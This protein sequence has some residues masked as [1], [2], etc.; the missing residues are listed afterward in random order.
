MD[1]ND[2]PKLAEIYCQRLDTAALARHFAAWKK[3]D[4]DAKSYI[5]ANLPTNDERYL[6]DILAAFGNVDYHVISMAQRWLRQQKLPVH[7]TVCGIFISTDGAK[8][9]QD[10]LISAIP[11]RPKFDKFCADI[12]SQP[13]EALYTNFLSATRNVVKT[14]YHPFRK[15]KEY[16]MGSE[17]EL[18]GVILD[19]STAYTINQPSNV[20]G[21]LSIGEAAELLSVREKQLYAWLQR[22]K[23]CCTCRNGR[24]LLTE[25]YVR[26]LRT[27]WSN[28]TP[29][30]PIVL[31]QLSVLPVGKRRDVQTIVMLCAQA[32][33]TWV[34]PD[35]EYPQQTV[36][37]Y[38]TNDVQSAREHI[39]GIIEKQHILPLRL[40]QNVTGLSLA[41]LRA[42]VESGCI[43]A[44]ASDG[45]FFITLAEQQRIVDINQRYVT[46]DVLVKVLLSETDEF[47]I[48]KV[49]HRS[50]LRDFI[51]Q[52]DWWDIDYID[53]AESPVDGGKFG[54]LIPCDDAVDLQNHI[55]C[56]IKGYG[57]SYA[58]Q[59]ELLLK[60]Y[61]TKLPK[62]VESLR[63]E[64]VRYLWEPNKAAVDMIDTL[65]YWLPK[66]LHTMLRTDLDKHIMCKFVNCTLASC[67]ELNKFLLK[68]GII[69]NPYEF[70]RTS[71]RVDTSAYSLVDYATMV[72]AI[73]CDDVIAE[74][75][76]VRKAV[77]NS[78]YAKLWLY[79]ALHMVASVRGTDYTRLEVPLLNV[80]PDDALRQIKQGEFPEGMARNLVYNFV[81]QITA[82]QM[83]PHKTEDKGLSATLYFHCPESCVPAFGR[84]LAIVSAHQ[85]IAQAP[86]NIERVKDGNLIRKFFGPV[87]AAACGNKDFAG[88][89]AN[90]ALMQATAAEA[91]AS[92]VAP[93]MAYIIA[94]RM[95]SHKGS[96]AELAQTTE[97]YLRNSSFKSLTTE[98]IAYLLTERGVCSFIVDTILKMHCGANYEQLSAKSQNQL[99]ASVGI[100]PFVL[101]KAM[102]YT[103]LAMD[104]AVDI[105]QKYVTEQSAKD[106]LATIALGCA[107]GKDQNTQCLCRAAH[108]PC[109]CPDRHGCLGC[110]YE[111][112]TKALLM[113][114]VQAYGILWQASMDA[115]ELEKRRKRWLANHMYAPAI[116]E[117]HAHLVDAKAEFEVY[118]QLISEVRDNAGA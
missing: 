111:I 10:F 66:E 86:H 28:I 43:S 80:A 22:H 39:K 100:H 40:L 70:E 30:T 49:G 118:H 7:D 16:W 8:E 69:K 50:S 14:N 1:Q 74:L 23:E 81:A 79:V 96:Y 51:V 102:R 46:L 32:H 26:Q 60:K 34:I 108:M 59:I 20:A 56:W 58:D 27:E 67:D 107:T 48:S 13:T 114:L 117:V 78:Q 12:G 38:Y 41:Q 103:Q 92:G 42:K 104:R 113:K 109:Q 110:Q 17:D 82:S 63:E 64:Y 97:I 44:T 62:T 68:V 83:R 2:Y 88:R 105:V 5:I 47:Q 4:I 106:I 116:A 91:D 57:K 76:L 33:P 19:W 72:A 53:S 89:R 18:Q 11:V 61:A 54:V 15:E 21:Y 65:L 9:L 90:K 94:S 3:T 24:W 99:I 45:E 36:G 112:A 77:E 75:D 55:E 29:I 31:E 37:I 73:V 115:S 98:E 85:M 6:G 87:F 71:L 101:D 52:N 35:R 95:R 25:E 93:R 84:I